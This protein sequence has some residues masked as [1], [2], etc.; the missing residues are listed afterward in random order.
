MSFNMNSYE[1]L[2]YVDDCIKLKCQLVKIHPFADGNGRSARALLNLYFKIVGLPPVYVT[3]KEKKEY[4]AAMAKAI[5]DAEYNPD[6]TSI[7]RFYYY[8]IC[9]SI[10]GLDISK[11]IQSS[12]KM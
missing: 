6:F 3:K 4:Q 8:K 11:Q 10:V 5:C 12:K 9:D 7:N 2:K 1:L